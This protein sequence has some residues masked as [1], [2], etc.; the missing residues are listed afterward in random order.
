M[1][2]GRKLNNRSAR[3]VGEDLVLGEL[4]GGTRMIAASLAHGRE[5]LSTVDEYVT[6]QSRF[7]RQSRVN[8]RYEV[9]EVTP[10]IFLDYVSSQVMAWS[11]DEIA[12]LKEIVA[13][14]AK[15]LALLDVTLPEEVWVV[16]TS[17][18]EEGYA[19]YTRL[20]NVIALPNNMVGSL[21]TTVNY[22]DPLHP[23]SDTSYLEDVITHECFHIF[24]KNNS[25]RRFAL[26]DLVGYASTGAPVPL[27][28]TPWGPASAHDTVPMLKIT[29]PDTPV[30]NVY[31]ELEV[32]EVP[33]GGTGTLVKRP[34]LPVLLASG[35]YEGG[36]FFDYL[37]WWFLAIEQCRGAWVPV[38]DDS[39]RPLFYKSEPL[40][41]QY[42]KMIGL[43]MTGELF[44]PDEILAQN[45]VLVVNQPSLGLLTEMRS[46]LAP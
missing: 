41:P 4:L 3:D 17:G 20:M 10:K 39:G 26:Y 45:F 12:S 14:M 15:K 32:P 28:D 29:N 6:N 2:S 37:A 35:P 13:S 38:L 40:M 44:H 46:I 24:S 16:K 30:L 25:E 36:I 31:I 43:N 1:K 8:L 7:D 9:V 23:A 27:P 5:L 42:L 18:L 11:D 33:G 21:Q 19:A 34:L 22:G